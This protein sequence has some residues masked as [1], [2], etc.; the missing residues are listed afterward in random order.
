M[1]RPL[2]ALLLLAIAVL[3]V[4]VASASAFA[5]GEPSE[6]PSALLPDSADMAAAIENGSGEEAPPPATDPRAAEGL[7]LENL[8]RD[9]ALEVLNGVFEAPLEAAAGIYDE[10]GDAKLLGPHVALIRGS[11]D[12]AGPDFG[13]GPSQSTPDREAAEEL[14]EAEALRDI[15]PPQA[16]P[17]E[18]ANGAELVD[19]TLPLEVG[20]GEP[21]DLSLV[22]QDGRLEPAAPLVETQIPEELD[23]RIEL[24]ELGI[25]IEL[26]A[27]NPQRTASISNGSVAFYPNVAQDADF[28]VSATPTGIETFMQLRSGDSPVSGVYRLSLPAGAE[29]IGTGAGG[30]EVRSG[31]DIL[32]SVPAPVAIDAAGKGVPVALDVDSASG[33]LTIKAEPESG[34]TYPVLVDPLFQTYEWSTKNTNVGICSSSFGTTPSGSCGQ[35]EEWGYKILEHY[36]G[37]LP[38]LI[39]RTYTAQPGIHIYAERQQEA[40]NNATAFYTVPRYFKESPAPTSFIKSVKFTNIVW[41]TRGS[42][43][44]P[45]LFVG[46]W[47]TVDS[48]WVQSYS[49]NSGNE[50][51]F[52]D[53][54]WAPEFT[55]SAPETHVKAAQVSL[56]DTESTPDSYAH[57]WVGGASVQLGDIEAPETP[58]QSSLSSAWV[59]KIA[60]PIFFKDTDSGLG[61]YAVSADTQEVDAYKKPLHSWRVANG[62]VGVGNSACPRTWSSSL[63]YDPSV[64]P[65]GV[66]YLRLTGEDPVGNKSASGWAEIR[67]DHIAPTVALTGSMTEQD[68]LG[69]R[70]ASYTLKATGSD[71]TASNPQSG[72]AKAEVKL[73][74]K[75]VAMEGKQLEE[76][77]PKCAT[78]NCPLAAEWTLDSSSLAEGTHTIEV[79]AKDAV[80][81]TSTKNLVIETRPAP[82]PS[83][84]LSGSI[85]EQASLGTERPRYLLK[86]QSTALAAGSEAPPLGTAPAYNS[87]IGSQGA[88]NG[89][90]EDPADVGADSSG[91]LWVLD[92]SWTASRLQEFNAKGEWI[93]TA[94]S[95]GSAAGQ[96]KNPTAMAVDSKNNLWVSDSGNTRIVEF[97]EKG[98]FVLTFGTNVNATKVSAGGSEAEK[99][100][101]TAASGNVCRAANTGSLPGQL[102]GPRGIAVTAGGN[103]WVVDA[104]NSRLQKFS[105]TGAVLNTISGEGTEPGK[106]KAP[107]SITVAPDGS[108]WVADTGNNRIEQWS[109]SL[110]FVRAVGK[111]GTGGGEF[112]S[113]AAIE[114]DSSGTI[115]VGDKGNNRVEQF[116]EVGSYVGSFGSPGAGTG[117]FAMASPMG[118]ALDNKGSIWITDP[119]HYRVQ[120]WLIPRFPAYNSTIGSQG[121]GN[122]QFE[123][124]A[125]V[126]A[127]SSGNLWV[128]DLSWTA[129]RLQEFNAK[130]EWIRT[131]GSQ[132]SAA[133]QLKNPTAMAVDSKNNLWVSDSGNTRIVEF[134]EKGE[135]VLTFGTNVNA[136][137]V[138][139]GGSEAEKN[140]CT[141]ASGNVCRAA[142]TG[143]LPGQL[144]GPRGIAVTAG[145]NIWVV[146]AGNSRLQKF[147]PTGAVLNTISGEGT[148]PGKLKAPTSIT[149]APDGSIW[150]ADTG[151]NRIEQWSS[152]LA[153]VRAVGK[154]GTGG[155]EFK[156]PAAIE[157]DS[158]GTIW[159]GDKGN[160]RVEVFGEGGRYFGQFGAAGSGRFS[161]TSPMGIAIAPDDSIWVTDPGHYTVQKWTQE[162][163]NSEITTRLWV[164]GVEATGLRGVCKTSRCT[165]EPQWFVNSAALSPGS[166]TARVKTTDGLG[167]STETTRNF[168]IAR[169]TTKPTLEAGGELANAPEGWVEQET[170]G[171]NATATD[172]ASGVTSISFKIDGQQVASV[173]QTCADGGCQETLSKQISMAAYSGGAHAA[174]IVATDGAGNTTTRSW[175]IN[176]D[177]EG[178]ISTE[179]LADTLEAVEATIDANLIGAPMPEA[180]EGTVAGLSLASGGAGLQASGSSVP[181]AINSDPSRGITMDISSSQALNLP[182]NSPEE[183][184]ATEAS[185][186]ADCLPP[187]TNY[188]LLQ[189]IVVVPQFV[190]STAGSVTSVEG[191]AATAANTSSQADTIVR[192][193]FDGALTFHNIRDSAAPEEYSWE[194]QLLP[195]Q[196][197]QL[198]D[199]HDVQVF[200]ASGHPA[201]AIQAQPASDAIGA[202]VPLSL[203]VKGNVVTE[204]VAHRSGQFVYPVVDGVG[205]EGGFISTEIQ[206]PK[207][208]QE[209]R[210][211]RERLEREK[212]EA[213]EAE[214]REEIEAQLADIEEGG[215]RLFQAYQG[216]PVLLSRQTNANPPDR[217]RA[218]RFN[219]CHFSEGEVIPFGPGD[220]HPGARLEPNGASQQCHGSYEEH[221]GVHNLTW[222]FA[223]HGLFHYRW[224]QEVWIEEPQHC[225]PPWGPHAPLQLNCLGPVVGHRYGHHIDVIDK[226]RW[227]PGEYGNGWKNVCGEID[228]V[229]STVPPPSENGERALFETLHFYRE[230][231]QDY[232]LPCGWDRL[233]EG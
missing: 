103:I 78:Q 40:G 12:A 108:I 111:E 226:A 11:Q 190:A 131:A 63:S 88:G 218:Y 122:G 168:Q 8:R 29:L 139:A 35:Q 200:F 101:C 231:R 44:S 51:G 164:D 175:T 230:Q 212:L 46:L 137:K 143:S 80:G 124:P 154:E 26:L 83:L 171:L 17:A 133:G 146:D 75:A 23:E 120:R 1:K 117:Q 211:E 71:G 52:N 158:S 199:P 184:E 161:L 221:D 174:Q 98:E 110:A 67:V 70:R 223:V 74:G 66:N 142:N 173:S 81:N 65:S 112:K 50:Q 10:L 119:G 167:R 229:L 91:N 3:C 15:G 2:G 206:G 197:M 150:V 145:G 219:T 192:P 73:D 227:Y 153:F 47:D 114:A 19:S 54:A 170:Y 115:W 113:P 93:R 92:L 68:S 53:P 141:A 129:S 118:I 180:I 157:A 220:I 43:W 193:L 172:S 191:N 160:N 151:N 222:A 107:T 62:C 121:A 100:L 134:N 224:G 109:S 27:A 99:N 64:L 22:H 201:F 69:T 5:S 21:L 20:S 196:Y 233:H 232:E 95:Q 38:H 130:G 136:T 189:P 188:E 165:I 183:E 7:Q 147:S 16:L 125:D 166:H 148:E 181:L 32:L 13:G 132:G 195:G 204:T 135:F 217:E 86:A 25:G 89:Q 149:V 182:C 9:E 208:E 126:G 30:A 159:V 55:N 45:Y 128:L 194:V 60:S 41:E 90:F 105:P 106:L 140:L 213:L 209:L 57:V 97:N 59:D 155:G 176:V 215:W 127:D 39:V 216:P 96:L 94:G 28:A 85:T 37:G 116:D 34:T 72:I 185:P 102:S 144:S 162:R 104:G 76:W 48:H 207:D 178:H 82:A 138:S 210:E 56:M 203:A 84:T 36:W 123:D 31:E 77:S 14:P 4:A 202:A 87:T 156:S 169:D 33:E 198:V 187:G 228:G 186:E 177:P 18:I 214:G 152:S 225:T 49:H 79:I 6:N 61:V 58:I 24:P 42:Y 163:P 179:E 205:W